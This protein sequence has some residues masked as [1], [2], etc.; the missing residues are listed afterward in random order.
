[1]QGVLALPLGAWAWLKREVKNK[2]KEK[3]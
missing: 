1:V 2:K 3:K